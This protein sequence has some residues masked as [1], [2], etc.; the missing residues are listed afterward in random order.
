MISSSARGDE[1]LDLEVSDVV[2]LLGEGGELVEVSCE[3]GEGSDLL[4]DVPTRQKGKI[5]RIEGQDGK[6]VSEASRCWKRRER[7]ENESS[8]AK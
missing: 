3:E 4:D 6:E 8:E 7:R 5:E 1:S 2:V